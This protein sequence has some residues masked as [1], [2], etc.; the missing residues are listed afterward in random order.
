M[1][2]VKKLEILK[3][4]K[5][6]KELIKTKQSHEIEPNSSKNRA[7]REGDNYPSL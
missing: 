6:V 7:M 3:N 5:A 4:M 2:M 1:L